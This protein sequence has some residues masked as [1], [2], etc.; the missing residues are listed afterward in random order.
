MKKISISVIFILALLGNVQQVESQFLKKLGQRVEDA[1]KEAVIRKTEQKVNR[2]T[3]KTMDTILDGNKGKKKISKKSKS[4]KKGD[5][6]EDDMNEISEAK[7]AESDF[8]V[9]SNF[10]FIPGNKLLF[11]DDFATDAIGDFPANWETGGSGEVVTVSD[12]EYNWL[13]L[14]RRS[15]YLPTLPNKFPENF[16]M[17]FDMINH[18][19]V[20]GTPSSR[21]SFVF[22][23]RK[24][25]NAG[26]GG[27]RAG[28]DILLSNRGFKVENVY[29]FGGDVEIGVGS[30][31]NREFPEYLLNTVHISIAVNNKRLRMWINEEKIV[32][33]PNVLQANIGDYFL[34]QAND[35]LPDKGHFVGISNFKIAE[36]SED[37]RSLLLKNGKFSTT[38][39]YFDTAAATVKKESYGILLDIANMLRDNDN[40]SLQIVGHTDSKGDEKY[41]LTLSEKR[42][43][44]VK[45]IL[46]E[47]F[48][49]RE[50]RLQF[51]GKG[52]TEAVD[53][54]NT[55]KGRANNRRVEFIKL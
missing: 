1:A 14:S 4:T 26:S 53:D 2:E 22:M 32:D 10:T 38:G 11:Y 50:D 5:N 48:G 27:T 6:Q 16:T 19:Y 40:I 20:A 45:E 36:S 3:E 51:K 25:Y 13:S 37:L 17:E 33:S 34:I 23:T 35:V 9:Y 29:N 52:E 8:G 47:E 46:V 18:G 31:I 43:A 7:N 24:A 41:N 42:A 39:I 49:I 12:S 55:E 54:N 28:I 21:I 15:G 44:A 30:T